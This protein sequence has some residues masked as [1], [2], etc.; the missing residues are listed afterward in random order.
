MTPN[1]KALSQK[2][3]Q[4]SSELRGLMNTLTRI[5][6]RVEIFID[7][8]E[9]IAGKLDEHISNCPVKCQMPEYLSRLSVL[10][11][12]TVTKNGG[13]VSKEDFNNH[14]EGLKKEIAEMREAN[15]EMELA[16]QKQQITTEKQENHWKTI[17]TFIFHLISYIAGVV[18]AAYIL[19]FLAI[20]AASP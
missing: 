12:T 4:V 9:Q 11:K 20:K 1:D 10:E 5:D 13:Y 15:K 17:G 18:A 2:F 16:T 19:H 8:Q 14:C 6:E 3:D 7:Q